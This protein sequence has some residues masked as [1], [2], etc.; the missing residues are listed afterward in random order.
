MTQGRAARAA[1]TQMGFRPRD[2]LYCAM[3]VFHG[4]ALSSMVFPALASGASLVFRRRFSASGFLPDV[5]QYGCTFTSTVGRALAYVLATPATEDDR[6]NRLRLVLAP[7]SSTE[8]MAAFTERF[9]PPVFGGYGSSENAIV[10]VPRP[11][12]PVEALGVPAPGLEVAV[13]DPETSQECPPR[14]LRRRPQAGQRG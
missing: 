7:E 10:M 3:P 6:D 5:R 9:G 8:D 2:V 12:Q 14:P 4:N 1:T 11:G 13:V